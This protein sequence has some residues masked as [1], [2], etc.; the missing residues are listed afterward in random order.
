MEFAQLFKMH[1]TALG[2]SGNNNGCHPPKIPTFILA[3]YR[4]FAKGHSDGKGGHGEH[5]HNK[6]HE[7]NTS[8]K[9]DPLVGYFKLK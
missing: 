9:P 4:N 5:F 6:A 8:T 7:I 2:W 3:G 1:R